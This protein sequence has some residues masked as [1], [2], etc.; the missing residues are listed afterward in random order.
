MNEHLH[1]LVLPQVDSRILVD[2]FRLL[3]A[4]VRDGHLH[5]LLVGLDKLRLRGVLLTRYSRRKHVVDRLLVA[6]FLDAYGT[7]NHLPG[8]VCRV[9]KVL[10]VGAP[11]TAHKVEVSETEHYWL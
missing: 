6:V 4:E 3:V 9:C 2:A 8:V 7:D 10:L 1:A 5:C 11:L